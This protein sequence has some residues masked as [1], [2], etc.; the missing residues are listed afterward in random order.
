VGGKEM[1]IVAFADSGYKEIALNWAKHLEDLKIHNYV[2]YALD[3]GVYEFLQIN[4]INTEQIIGSWFSSHPT[5]NKIKEDFL[6]LL[7]SNPDGAISR[8]SFNNPKWSKLSKALKIKWLR[9]NIDNILYKKRYSQG[10]NCVNRELQPTQVANILSFK[11]LIKD[12]ADKKIPGLIMICE[13]DVA[14]TE[15]GFD[16]LQYMLSEESLK[17]NDL[18]INKP[19]LIQAGSFYDPSHHDTGETSYFSKNRFVSNACFVINYR[20]AE[21]Y[22]KHYVFDGSTKETISDRFIHLRLPE[23]DKNIQ[24]RSIEPRPAYQT[25]GGIRRKFSSTIA[26][27]WHRP[28]VDD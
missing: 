4:N 15:K 23:M 21:S 1:I 14:F 7:T 6:K 25:S 18:D 19:L 10:C 2:V 22:L 26:V 9:K 5:T 17:A 24:S 8:F 20:F 28:V 12:V 16:D 13:D 11:Y 27:D 3:S